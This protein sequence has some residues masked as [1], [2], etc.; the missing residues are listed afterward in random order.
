MTW[1]WQPVSSTSFHGWRVRSCVVQ[2]TVGNAVRGELFT[3]LSHGSDTS[4][5]S[6]A[7]GPEPKQSPIIVPQSV[8]T[9]DSEKPET[10]HPIHIKYFYFFW[11]G[12]HGYF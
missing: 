7:S 6:V 8:L 5:Q 9:Q 12:H 3:F 10:I 1:K 2:A 11:S 4:N